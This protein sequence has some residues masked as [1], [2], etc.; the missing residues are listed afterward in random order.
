MTVG[1][2]LSRRGGCGGEEGIVTFGL[3]YNLLRLCKK[4]RNRD[5]G[6][7]GSKTFF[8]YDYSGWLPALHLTV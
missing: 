8:N 5:G 7:G 1:T 2:C 6:R 3:F 4:W